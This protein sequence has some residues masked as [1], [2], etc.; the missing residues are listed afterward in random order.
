MKISN[1]KIKNIKCFKEIEIPFEDNGEIK[2]WSLVV[3][4]NGDGKTTILRCLA[5]GLCDESGASALLAELYGF[6]REHEE[7]GSIEVILKDENEN[8]KYQINTEITL[9]GN[10]ESV[11]Q[12]IYPLNSKNERDKEITATEL[13]DLRDKIFAIAYGSG[14]SITGTESYEEYA[15]VDSVYYLFNYKHPLQNAELGARRIESKS[16]KQLNEL[17]NCLKKILMLKDNDEIILNPKGLFMKT[18]QWGLRSFNSLSDGYQSLTTV[19]IDFL[20]WRLLYDSKSFDLSKTSGIFI[21]DE[22]EQHLHPKWQRNIINIL[23]QQFRNIQFIGG[24]H[25]PICALGLNDLECKSQL[26]KTSYVN[27][28]SEVESLD[29][30]ETYKGYRVDQILTSDIFELTSARS[31]KMQKTLEDYQ[32]IYLKRENERTTQEIERMK[33]IEKELKDLPMWDTLRDKRIREQLSHLLEQNQGT[34]H[35]KD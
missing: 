22:V 4:N 3:G 9:K 11:S 28:H 6:L 33:Q 35:D 12:K 29:M 16:K 18:N 17:T 2:K 21:I 31:K 5:L 26:I 23:A 30:K 19:I 34:K 14:R 7:K 32:N 20:S 10:N 25:T 27:N 13:N 8:K 1:L 15:V 24:T